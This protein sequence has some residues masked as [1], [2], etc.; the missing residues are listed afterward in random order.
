MKIGIDRLTVYPGRLWVDALALAQARGRDREQVREQV[1]IERRTVVPVHEDAVTLAVNAANSILTPEDR[2]Q[3]E[4][5]IVGTESS[6]DFGKAL[7][8]WV[9]HFC[10]LRPECRTFEVKNACYGGTAALDMAASWIASGVRPGKKALVISADFM[11]RCT[12]DEHDMVGGGCAVAMI[13]SQ[14]PR[15]VELEL[16][17]AGYWTHEITDAFRPTV[18]HELV[19]SETS[20]Y[21]YLDALEGAYESFEARAPALD[22]DADVK[23]HIYHAPFPGMT[24]QAHRTLLR[25]RGITDPEAIARSFDQKVRGGLYFG[26]R[27]GTAYGASTFLSLLGHLQT[28]EDLRAGD[29]LSVFAYG[30]GCQGEFY[31]A[32]L[33]A[34]ACDAVRSLDLDRALAERRQISLEEFERIE[35][36]RD[37]YADRPD[38][39]V[40]R[41]VVAGVYEELYAGR[42]L[43]VLERV[44]G[45]RRVYSWS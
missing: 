23:R 27:L 44:E 12:R 5:V 33:G 18:R 7:S 37:G 42:K 41:D 4:L 19:D 28:G 15:L 3:I 21:A 36:V 32:R 10:G 45:Y 35:H 8:T 22:F 39:T 13:V 17:H 29:R 1:M 9:H 2:A 43:L 6:V 14:D 16:E 34:G 38:Y 20:L 40:E 11:R 25:C 24:L 31:T 26:Q 30:S